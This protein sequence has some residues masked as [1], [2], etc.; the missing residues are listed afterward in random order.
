MSFC[1]EATLRW[2]PRWEARKIRC[3]RL[4]TRRS[5]RRQ[6]TV[7]Q[8]VCAVAPLTVA[9]PKLSPRSAIL[10]S[11]FG[12]STGSASAAFRRGSLRSRG[13][14]QPVRGAF[15][16]LRFPLP[17]GRWLSLLGSSSPAGE[18]AFLTVGLLLNEQTPTGFPRSARSRRD[19]GGCLHYRGEAWCPRRKRSSLRPTIGDRLS[20]TSIGVF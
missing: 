15:G 20:L 11:L 6:S 16:P 18:F 12:R 3:R 8:S 7:F 5:A 10:T 19:R 4:R 13:P 2:S 1:R 14:V 9:C 17:F